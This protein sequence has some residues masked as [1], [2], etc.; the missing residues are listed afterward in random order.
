MPHG[1]RIMSNENDY[2]EICCKIPTF[3]TFPLFILQARS[4]LLI[5]EL[6]LYTVLVKIDIFGVIINL[7]I[8][9]WYVKLEGHE[10]TLKIKKKNREKKKDWCLTI[11]TWIFQKYCLPKKGRFVLAFF[12]K[13]LTIKQVFQSWMNKI[14]IPLINMHLIKVLKQTFQLAVWSAL[15]Y[16]CPRGDLI[17]DMVEQIFLI[18]YSSFWELKWKCYL[19]N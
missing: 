18:K 13:K 4:L 19:L 3:S 16:L 15:C 9:R 2:R 7:T 17:L 5:T 6:E 12:S 1:P 11:W 10:F 8:E 14:T